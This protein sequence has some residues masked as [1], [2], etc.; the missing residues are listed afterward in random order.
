MKTPNP[1]L[2]QAMGH[3]SVCRYEENFNENVDD[4]R[5]MAIKFEG[6]M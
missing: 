1:K 4:R 6:S 2:E 3:R 5:L